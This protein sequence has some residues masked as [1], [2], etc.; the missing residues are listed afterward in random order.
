MA[1]MDL[2]N[3]FMERFTKILLTQ[4]YYPST[5]CPLRLSIFH[6]INEQNFTSHLQQ[7]F[8]CLLVEWRH[9][10]FDTEVT[11]LAK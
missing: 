3:S 1:H 8:L 11:F 4:K 10:D 2:K 5:L 9:S 7:A 6:F